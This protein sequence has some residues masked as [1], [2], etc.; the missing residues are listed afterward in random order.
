M[1]A[2]APPQVVV[3]AGAWRSARQ[4]FTL[5]LARLTARRFEPQLFGMVYDWAG[6][7]PSPTAGGGRRGGVRTPDPLH[8]KQMLYH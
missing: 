4:G 3:G 5:F 2:L 1:E 7:N 8:V 6:G